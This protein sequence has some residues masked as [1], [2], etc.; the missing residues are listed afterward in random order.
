MAKKTV[1][2]CDGAKFQG[3]CGKLLTSP[4]D[5]I[6]LRGDIVDPANG[7]VLV[8]GSHMSQ[9]EKNPERGICYA[10]LAKLLPFSAQS[11]V[12]E[13]PVEKIVYRDREVEKIVHRKCDRMHY[14]SS[15]SSNYGGGGGSGRASG[16]LP[17]PELPKGVRS[18]VGLVRATRHGG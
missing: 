7:S 17:P 18:A 1:V 16:P 15:D 13:K 6:L 9:G 5:G 3:D 8:P 11:R 2:V 10:C 14:D 4:A 12:V